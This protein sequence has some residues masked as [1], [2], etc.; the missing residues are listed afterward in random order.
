MSAPTLPAEPNEVEVMVA[1]PGGL[2]GLL[3]TNPV[4]ARFARG[5]V[6]SVLGTALGQALTMAAQILAARLLGKEPFGKF[7][8]VNNTLATF[9]LMAGLGLSLTATKHV[10]EW[11]TKFPERAGRVLGLSALSAVTA[12]LVLTVLLVAGASLLAR[13]VLNAPE[14]APLLRLGAPIILLSGFAGAQTGALTGFEAFRQITWLNVIRGVASFPIQVLGVLWFGLPGLVAGTVLVNLVACTANETVLRRVCR[15]HG[16][17][18]R[19]RQARQEAHVLWSF[20][21]PALLSNLLVGA[22]LWAANAILVQQPGG[23]GEMGVLSAANQWKML[24]VF[25]PTAVSNVAVPMVS[26]LL[27]SDDA[28]GPGR[29]VELVH[30]VNQLALWP[31]AVFVMLFAGKIAIAY[32][33]AFA[34]GRAVFIVLVGGTS[35]GYVSAAVSSLMTSRGL[36]WFG[37]TMN[38]IWGVLVLAVTA[39]GA[40]HYGALAL[41]VGTTTGYAVLVGSFVVY[42]QRGREITISLARRVL[43]SGALML[44]ATVGAVALDSERAAKLAVPLAFAAVPFS[45]LFVHPSLRTSLRQALTRLVRHRVPRAPQPS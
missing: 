20:S 43:A 45:L 34:S 4:A 7:G 40:A 31:V 11:R 42:M 17:V 8:M 24:L 29:T 15:R 39:A 38:L 21:L 19:Y 6:W 16:V 32:G 41:A 33:S 13:T 2:R 36:M 1:R 14:L 28:G 5:A 27:N 30:A 3:P 22:V 18:V 44:T 35:V 9:G 23:Y 25:I 26:H 37:A 10:A 12:G